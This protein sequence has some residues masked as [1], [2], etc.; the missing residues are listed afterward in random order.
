ME[1][2]E[3][4]VGCRGGVRGLIV[5]Q[6]SWAVS[7]SIISHSGLSLV[8]MCLYILTLS[9][10]YVAV[11]ALTAAYTPFVQTAHCTLH[12]HIGTQSAV[13]RVDIPGFRGKHYSLKG[14]VKEWKKCKPV[15]K[16]NTYKQIWSPYSAQ[17]YINNIGFLWT[18]RWSLSQHSVL[19]ATDQAYGPREK[20]Q[21]KAAYTASIQHSSLKR[22]QLYSRMLFCRLQE[23]NHSKTEL[24][25]PTFS[26]L[27]SHMC[28]TTSNPNL[29]RYIAVPSVSVVI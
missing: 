7:K 27:A 18:L 21:N 3:R 26:Q 17:P 8:H 10:Q 24:H 4:V 9:S 25:V 20:G 28:K 12:A 6:C 14:I 11:S 23:G 22:L 16:M 13:I 2:T 15:H 5:R 29:R 19:Q 1:A